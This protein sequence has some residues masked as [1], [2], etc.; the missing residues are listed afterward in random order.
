MARDLW[1]QWLLELLHV[2]LFELLLA[3]HIYKEIQSKREWKFMQESEK[4]KNTEKLEAIRHCDVVRG[5]Y[6]TLSS[7]SQV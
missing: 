7:L 5:V 3:K 6:W 4:R 2:F 1:K